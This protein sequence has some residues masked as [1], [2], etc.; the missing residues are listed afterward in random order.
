M[1]TD[2]PEDE[3]VTVPYIAGRHL[4]QGRV[5]YVLQVSPIDAESS[6]ED[7]FYY[8]PFADLEFNRGSSPEIVPPFFLFWREPLFF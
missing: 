8:D 2:A 1:S 6:G 4:D 7:E 3:R 5:P